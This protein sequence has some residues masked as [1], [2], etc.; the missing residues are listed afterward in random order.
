VEAED[1]MERT[2]GQELSR[3]QLLLGYTDDVVAS[4]PEDALDLRFTDPRGGYFFSAR[5]LMMH[6][7]D[8]RWNALAWVEGEEVS[9]RQF[10]QEYG[11]TERAW[12]F[13]MAE[14][15]EILARLGESRKGIDALLARPAGDMHLITDYQREAH[16]QRIKASKSQGLDTASLEAGG[17]PSLVDIVLFLVAHEQAHRAELQWLMRAHGKDVHRLR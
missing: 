9:E 4:I 7:A 17:P 14:K 3:A 6:I 10:R 16:E 12:K 1:M 2:I 11:G 8:T 5:E 15:D 13:A